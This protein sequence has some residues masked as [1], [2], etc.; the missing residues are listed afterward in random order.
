M[1]DPKPHIEFTSVDLTTGWEA[2]AGYK[3]G[4]W[5]K[6]LASDFDEIAK[7]GSRSRLV[8]MD[9]G[10]FSEQPFVHDYWEE[11]YVL[12]GDLTVGNDANGNGGEKFVAPIY[13]CRPPGAAHGPVKS[14]N[15]CLV[16]EIHYYKPN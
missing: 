9:A 5:Q 7:T 11:V 15:G 13:A 3:D 4:F 12:K 10:A 8:R 14:E 1:K 6:I 16:F 2:P